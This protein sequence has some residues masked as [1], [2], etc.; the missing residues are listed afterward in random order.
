MASHSIIAGKDAPLEHSI[1]TLGGLLAGR[2]FDLEE[3]SWL[4]PVAGVWSV[5]LRDRHCPMLY[6]NGKGATEQAAR[7]S[8][9]GEFVERAS[10]HHFWSHYYL[11]ESRAR[12]DWVHYPQERWF[13]IA[14]EAWPEGLLDDTLKAFYNPDDAIAAETLVD[15]NSGNRERGICALPYT[16]LSD[17]ETLWFPINLIGN[18][19]VSNGL[20]AGNSPREARA[21]AMSE[22]LERHVKF[23]VI[24]EELCLPEVPDSVIDRYP[25]IRHGIDQLRDAGYGILVRDASLGGRYPVLCVVLLNPQDHGCYASFGAHPRFAIALERA[26]TELLQGRA[27]DNLAQFPEPSFDSEEVASAENREIHFVDSSGVI[28]WRFLADTPDHPFCD[29]QFSEDNESDY[30]WLRN[31]IEADGFDIYVADFTELGAYACRV[32]VPGMSEIYDVDDLEW[33][34]NSVGNLIRPALLDLPALDAQ[35]SAALLDLIERLGLADQR[36]VAELIGLAP[37]ET[38]PWK[39]L[40]VAELKTL[41]GLASGHEE[42]VRAG[43]HWLHHFGEL[44]AARRRVYRAVASL[45]EMGSPD[46]YA[47]SLDLLYGRDAVA[48]ARALLSGELRHFGL[49]RLGP[50]MAGSA[51]HTSLLAA[52]DR[53][54]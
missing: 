37:D 41:L 47:T 21:Q 13:P 48:I 36:L 26:L 17:G 44:P 34:N 2:G 22:I 3:A 20:S 49:E 53:L 29:W 15:L 7:A 42:T 10:C 27:L 31:T 1:A 43:C 18:L 39:T 51:R 16:R 32:I 8:A 52:F 11:G 4:N 46:D 23:R 30:Q 38:S 12:R 28:G 6:T 14:G 35:G 50:D 19:Y 9:L 54:A 25:G 24:G 45:L 40:R 5:H 33:E